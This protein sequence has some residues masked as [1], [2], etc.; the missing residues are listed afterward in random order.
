MLFPS[1]QSII[2]QELSNIDRIPAERKILLEK[3]GSY[4]LTQV[5]MGQP[6]MLVYICTHNSRRS[7]MGQIWGKVA[8]TYFGIPQVM[9][10]S[11]GTEAT[12]FHPNA[13]EALTSQGFVIEGD[14][15]IKNPIYT[16][17]FGTEGE[18]T[19]CF[20]KVYDDPSNPKS[21]F[22]AVMTCSDAD[23]NCPYVPGTTARIATTYED[24]KK[25]DHTSIQQQMYVER[26]LQIARES[27]YAMQWVK[28]QR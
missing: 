17:S 25:F 9:T 16:V 7:H 4:V 20:S 8:A 1:I 15:S 22:C 2:Q 11:G 26:S 21:G 6:S 27:L 10:Y 3:I 19:T 12:A 14:T 13:I 24:P 28:N 23:E 18:Q 5:T